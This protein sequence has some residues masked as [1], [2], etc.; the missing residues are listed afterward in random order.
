MGDVAQEGEA[1]RDDGQGQ[2]NYTVAARVGRWKG[3][4]IIAAQPK[5]LAAKRIGFPLADRR[6]NKSRRNRRDDV[7]G[8]AHELD[9]AIG[10]NDGDIENAGSVKSKTLIDEGQFFRAHC[11]K[12]GLQER[13]PDIDRHAALGAGWMAGVA[14]GDA[15]VVR[16]NGGKGDLHVLALANEGAIQFPLVLPGIGHAA[17]A[18][19]EGRPRAVGR[20]CPGDDLRYLEHWRC[21]SRALDE[22]HLKI[23]NVI[24]EAIHHQEIGAPYGQP[25]HDQRRSGIGGRL[26]DAVGNQREVAAVCRAPNAK[27]QALIICQHTVGG[28]HRHLKVRRARHKADPLHVLGRDGLPWAETR[29]DLQAVRD[30]VVVALKGVH[31]TQD[32]SRSAVVGKDRVIPRASPGQHLSAEGGHQNRAERQG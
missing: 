3:L 4:R 27:L 26:I 23:T 18:E 13:R 15:E 21:R 11:C 24:I 29:R 10:L 17:G 22:L 31:L 25:I 32:A 2:R 6:L 19:W 28:P 20:R 5:L 9:A 14:G 1:G 7:Q 16:P 30:R 12:D 8:Q